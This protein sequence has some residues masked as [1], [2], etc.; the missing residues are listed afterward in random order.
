[1]T[2]PFVIAF[3]LG[4]AVLAGLTQG[5]TGFGFVMVAGPLLSAITD[6]KLAVPAMIIQTSATNLIILLHARSDLRVRRMW[7]LALSGMVGVPAGTLVLLVVDAAVLRLLMGLIVTVAAIAMLLGWRRS[8]RKEL[9]VSLPVGFASGALNSSTGLAGP[10]VVLFYTNQALRAREF[11]ANA[12]AHF[13]MLNV[14][15]IPSFYLAG[16]FTRTALVYGTQLLP[17]TLAGVLTGI[18]IHRWLPERLFNR[19][20]LSLVVAAGVTAVTAGLAGI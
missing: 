6:P 4:I 12:V 20:A 18:A 3:S 15:T 5:I 2:H 10:P 1:M 17:A 14:V 16:L 19:L 11:R 13:T 7:L 9:A 8:F